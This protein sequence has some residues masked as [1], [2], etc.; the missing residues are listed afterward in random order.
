MSKRSEKFLIHMGL[1]NILKYIQPQQKLI[2]ISTNAVFRG[3]CGKGN[4]SENE[5][6]KYINSGESLDLY[7]NAKIDGEKIVKKHNNSIIIRPGA[8][9]GQDING[10]WDKRISELINRQEQ[11]KKVVRAKNLYNTF[12]KVDEVANAVTELIKLDYKGII[13][14][15]PHKR[16]S[17]YDYYMKMSIKLN[18]NS[19]LIKSN[20]L[21]EEQDLSLNTSKS[22]SILGNIFSNV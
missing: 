20:V 3:N 21:S 10:K 6:P 22:R 8:I 19:D 14:L 5:E 7:A 2:F 9:Y 16:E 4:Y 15:G 11:Q 17:Y 12:V 18:L 1:N 13:H